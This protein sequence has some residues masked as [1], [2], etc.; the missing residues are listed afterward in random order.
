MVAIDRELYLEKAVHFHTD[1][2]LTQLL[3]ISIVECRSQMVITSRS[4]N[5][6]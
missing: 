5:G 3:R 2:G 6:D 1:D 4:W